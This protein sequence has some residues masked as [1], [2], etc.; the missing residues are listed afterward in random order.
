MAVTGERMARNESLFREVNERVA[1]VSAQMD[2]FGQIDFLCE[3]A[4]DTC[5]EAVTL[6][7]AEYEFVRSDPRQF[8]VVP[9]HTVRD[10][11]VVLSEGE[12]YAIVRKL[13]TAGRLAEATDPR[14]R[15]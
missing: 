6:S 1:E 2:G 13:G 11:E 12:R 9:G 14:D 3:C 5:K 4:D 10:I 8:L 7:R 15:P